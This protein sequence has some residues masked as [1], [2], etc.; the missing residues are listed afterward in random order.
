MVRAHN[1]H[2]SGPV[3]ESD[4]SGSNPA[5]V[6]RLWQHTAHGTSSACK[7]CAVRAS[8]ATSGPNTRNSRSSGEP[9]P[10]SRHGTPFPEAWQRAGRVDPSS[11]GR[12][13][14]R[15]L[16]ALAAAAVPTTSARACQELYGAL[17]SRQ[18]TRKPRE[19]SAGASAL[20]RGSSFRAQPSA[21]SEPRSIT[22]GHYLKAA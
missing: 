7:S 21:A 17:A 11:T 2:E 8:W 15:K 6:Q 14:Q 4:H 12:S 16:L 22:V 3:H 18:A 19:S 9:Q 20:R 10:P 1:R 5:K 13:R